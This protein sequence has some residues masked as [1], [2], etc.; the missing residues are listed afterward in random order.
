MEDKFR[1]E[2]AVQLRNEAEELLLRGK[3]EGAILLYNKSIDIFPTAEAHTYRGW[4]FSFQGRLDAAIA[5]CKLAILLDP[6]FG[7]PYNDIGSYLIAQGKL[8]EAVTWLEEAKLADRYDPR[9][10]PYMNLGRIYA[11]KGFLLRAIQEFE[12]ALNIV[13]G[14][15]ACLAAIED[16]R[17][18][19]H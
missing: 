8:D 7:N 9:H 18:C 2:R 3:L 5:E 6:A 17:T 19:L 13:P 11:A 15:P 4:A 12:G 1:K 10:F 14:E 16:L